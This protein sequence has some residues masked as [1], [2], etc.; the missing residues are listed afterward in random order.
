MELCHFSFFFGTSMENTFPFPSPR[1]DS[2]FQLEQPPPVTESMNCG[3]KPR[4]K[5]HWHGSM[6]GEGNGTPLQCSCLENPRDRGAWWAAVY[7]VT[8]SW[9]RLKRLSSSSSSSS[10]AQWQTLP[11]NG[12]DAGDAGLA[13]E[14][15]RS[16]GGGNGN[17][18]QYSRLSNAMDRAA[19]QSTAVHGVSKSQTQLSTRAL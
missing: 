2:C 7:G 17:A 12:E 5:V 1:K 4:P 3:T 10:M 15:G 13:S 14:A 19:W 9:T 18:L 16:P 11:A 8:Q 6:V